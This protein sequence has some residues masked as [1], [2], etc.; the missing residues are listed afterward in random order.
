MFLM[1][2]LRPEALQDHLF[3]WRVQ[4]C[5]SLVPLSTKYS[6]EPTEHNTGK[7]KS[8]IKCAKVSPNKR[9]A[10]PSKSAR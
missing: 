1:G 9:S 6:A 8:K 3:L 5:Y 2:L 4:V 10:Q 7:E